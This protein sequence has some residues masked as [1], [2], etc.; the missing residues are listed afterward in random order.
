MLIFL[1]WPFDPDD[2]LA[3][4]KTGAAGNFSLNGESSEQGDVI[5]PFIRVSAGGK[6]EYFLAY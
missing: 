2:E 3:T 1:D 4:T 5:E 6:C